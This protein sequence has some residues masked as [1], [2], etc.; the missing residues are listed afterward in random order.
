MIADSKDRIEATGPD[1]QSGFTL[2]EILIVIAIIGTL[3]V[4]VAPTLLGQSEQAKRDMAKM[5]IQKVQGMLDFYRARNGIYPT[6]EQGLQALVSEPQTE[7]RPTNYQPG[8]YVNEDQ[9]VD[10]WRRPFQ[11]DS[12]GQRNAYGVDIC[13]LGPDGQQS[14]DDI[15]NYKSDS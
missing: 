14:P 3:A 4:F 2:L 11:Y 13:S 15:C 12:P 9:I 8:G 5:Q 7:P 10:P 6:S 1:D